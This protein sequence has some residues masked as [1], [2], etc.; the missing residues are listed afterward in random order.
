MTEK[1]L[2][3]MSPSS[4][5]IF[6][7]LHWAV[8]EKAAHITLLLGLLQALISSSKRALGTGSHVDQ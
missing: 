1:R 5:L 8:L 7:S 3:S 2:K 6:F 4:K